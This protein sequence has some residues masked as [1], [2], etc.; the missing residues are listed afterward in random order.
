MATVT[1]TAPT[2]TD[3]AIETAGSDTVLAARFEQPRPA[4]DVRRLAQHLAALR[5]PGVEGVD[6]ID[7]T[8]VVSF[9]PGTITRGHLELLIHD[10]AA[11]I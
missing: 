8:L 11:H 10:A 2:P 7:A 6:A 9:D 5:M 1:M 3:L 4:R